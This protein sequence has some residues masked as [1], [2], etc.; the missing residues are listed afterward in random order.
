M[1][2]VYK[3][4]GRSSPQGA[5]EHEA[6][7]HPQVKLLPRLRSSPK[8]SQCM[9]AGVSEE[10]VSNAAPQH[11]RRHFSNIVFKATGFVCLFGW[12]F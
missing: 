11:I 8:C 5:D 3:A 6:H 2:P 7:L 12:F 1:F 9:S 4:K 10:E